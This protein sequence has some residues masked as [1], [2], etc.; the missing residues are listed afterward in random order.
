MKTKILVYVLPA[1]ILAT[2]QLAGAQQ[3]AKVPRIGVL[4]VGTEKTTTSLKAFFQRLHELGYLEGKNIVV[5]YRYAEG[6]LERL[7][8]LA[9]ELVRSNVAVI[10]TSGTPATQAAKQATSTIP[11]VVGTAGDLVGVGLVASLA[12]PGGNV[13]GLTAISPNL[14]G[15]RLELLTGVLPKA[16]R[17][18]VLWYP[19]QWDDMEVKQT[20]SVA[21]A[22]GV[23]IQSVQVR[24]PEDFQSAYATM[25]R[26]RAR[27]VIIIQTG[28]TGTY[29]TQLL[30][31]AAKNRL[32]SMCDSPVW[33]DDGC[34]MSY[35]PN[36]ADLYRRAAVYVDKILKG[37]KPSDLPVEQPTKFEFIINLKTAKQIGL[38]IPP[39]MLA[40]AN[41]VLK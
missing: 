22:L 37:T 30:E 2:I 13:T 36:R 20:E 7:P 3:A 18:A 23:Q 8:A 17:V 38:T 21:Q 5:E 41:K 29:R 28:F 27:A 26:E 14:S 40:R 15:K 33:A 32:A 11:I 9:A 16:S 31:L 39:N 6:K 25:I 34:L 10:V 35:G 4:M 24:R 12:K 19:S 1:L